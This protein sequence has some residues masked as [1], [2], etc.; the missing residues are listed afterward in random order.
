MKDARETARKLFNNSYSFPEENKDAGREWL[1]LT[2]NLF[3]NENNN[4]IDTAATDSIHTQLDSSKQNLN[5]FKIQ[6]TTASS[7]TDIGNLNGVPEVVTTTK[8]LS[9]V[10][11]TDPTACCVVVIDLE[12]TG[13]SPRFNRII[14]L[15]ATAIPH[16]TWINTIGH[17]SSPFYNLANYS[18]IK[19]TES[20]F[21]VYIKSS[22]ISP[23]PVAITK[24]TGITDERLENY[25]IPFSSAWSQFS[26]WLKY[27]AVGK[28]I[29]L[30]AHNGNSFD[31]KFIKAELTRN[32]ID[33]TQWFQQNNVICG[34]DTLHILRNASLWE[35]SDSGLT[36]SSSVFFNRR[37]PPNNF[38]LGDVYSHVFGKPLL[39]GHSAKT[40]CLAVVEILESE[41]IRNKWR[42]IANEIKIKF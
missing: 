3:V 15:A 32:K 13:F 24:L 37:A 14:Q 36:S 10:D 2:E 39:G 19:N 8:K 6:R 1:R 41:A 25:G 11:L 21:E 7:K 22:E 35:R 42:V 5:P 26:D 30:A 27:V 40:D 38:A 34:L 16:Q 33:S 31:Y 4:V 20:S 9:D 12:T 23:L 18:D 29:V 17:E 28:P